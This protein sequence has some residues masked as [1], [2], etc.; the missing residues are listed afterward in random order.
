MSLR[1]ETLRLATLTALRDLIDA[2]VVNLRRGT[3]ADLIELNETTG[4][5]S[6]DVKLPT[7]E[8]V[9]RISLIGVSAKPTVTDED[10][11]LAWVAE[12]HP[13]EVV[14]VVRPSFQKALLD[15]CSPVDDVTCVDNSTGEVVPG[16]TAHDPHRTSIRVT[17]T[18]GEGREAIASAWRDGTLVVPLLPERLD[19]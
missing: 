13:T 11:F 14:T 4:T 19:S 5:H 2:E 1:D 17:Y 18:K 9:A 15:R 6:V 12:H 7:G 10:T 8:R 16:V 3:T